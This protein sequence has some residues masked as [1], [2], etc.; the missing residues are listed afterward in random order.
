MSFIFTPLVVTVALLLAIWWR[1]MRDSS[2][3]ADAPGRLLASAVRG[4]PEE[5]REWGA[6]M[7]SEL[8]QIHGLVA[9]WRFALGCARVALFPPRRAGLWRNAMTG[10]SPICGMLAV[11]LPPLGL[12]FIYLA[13]VIV[14][15]IGGS[16]YTQS[17][18]W[19]DPD[20]VMT[21]VNFIVKL[22]FFC[23]LAGLPLGLAGWLRRER[24]RWLSLLGM[25]LSVCVIGYFFTVMHFTA[26]GPN[27]D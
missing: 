11:A 3:A 25:I 21:V 1:R 27:G 17:S 7:K 15:A 16:P 20:A 13:A 23:Q 8:G 2:A 14:Q 9:R 4:M 5:Q 26:G 18:R 6:A 12:P 19:S 24:L 22:M 10:R